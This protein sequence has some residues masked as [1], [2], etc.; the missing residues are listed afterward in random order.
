MFDCIFT[1]DYAPPQTTSASSKKATS[2]NLSTADHFKVVKVLKALDNEQLIHLGTALGLEYPHLKRMQ[3]LPDDMVF[4]WLN[5]E[6]EVMDTS[7]I[8]TWS[9]LIKALEDT[10]QKG[11]ASRIRNGK[12]GPPNCVDDHVMYCIYNPSQSNTVTTPSEPS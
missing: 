1:P 5:M 7:G 6:D 4:A 12:F 10:D 11:V 8:P 9:S 2:H 3:T